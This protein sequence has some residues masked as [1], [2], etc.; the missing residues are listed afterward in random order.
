MFSKRSVAFL[1]GSSFFIAAAAALPVTMA[2]EVALQGKADM[3]AY[4]EAGLP[5]PVVIYAYGSKGNLL[6]VFGDDGKNGFRDMEKMRAAI[7][8]GKIDAATNMTPNTDAE[9]RHFLADQN[10]RPETVIGENT[11]YRLILVIPDTAGAPCP[12]CSNYSAMLAD[13]MN[14]PDSAKKFSLYTLKLGSPAMKIRTV[15]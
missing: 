5:D 15:K 14:H 8:S 11:P 13:A 2:T 9:F 1:A 3:V 6:R 7:A 10:M 12:P 4:H